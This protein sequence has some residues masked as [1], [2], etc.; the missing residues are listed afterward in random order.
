LL[1]Q[2]FM[3]YLTFDFLAQPIPL[4]KHAQHTSRIRSRA[5]SFDALNC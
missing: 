5:K 2:F 4:G 1:V 3:A